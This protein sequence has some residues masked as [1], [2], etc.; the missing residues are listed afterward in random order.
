MGVELAFGNRQTW[1]TV[2]GMLYDELP[3][4]SS[5][6]VAAA[7]AGDLE[8]LRQVAHKLAGASSYCGTPALSHQAKSL[9]ILAEKG[10]KD[11]ITNAVDALLQQIE[12][13]QALKINGNLPDD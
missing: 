7:T 6:L 11:S 9:E 3:G 5:N 1:R 2:L 8:K 10:D 12:R 13:L 4:Y